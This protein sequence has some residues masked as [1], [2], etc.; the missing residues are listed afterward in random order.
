M[1]ADTAWQLLGRDQRKA[2]NG[3]P[4]SRKGPGAVDQVK[5]GL[6]QKKNY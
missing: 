5:N 6:K 1:G 4:K 2:V 3:P